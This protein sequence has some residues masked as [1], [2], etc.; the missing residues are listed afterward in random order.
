LY[1]SADSSN[2]ANYA[3]ATV[4]GVVGNP[5]TGVVTSVVCAAD[6]FAVGLRCVKCSTASA[7]TLG[8]SGG[9]K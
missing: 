4:T 8:C 3:S 2:K 9:L 6:S 7:N 1:P 5:G